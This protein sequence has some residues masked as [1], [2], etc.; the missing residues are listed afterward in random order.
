MPGTVDSRLSYFVNP[1]LLA[2]R[3]GV[4]VS[5]AR[6]PSVGLVAGFFVRVPL[7]GFLG[8]VWARGIKKPAGDAGD[9]AGSGG[10]GIDG[11]R[12]IFVTYLPHLEKTLT[13]SKYCL[14]GKLMITLLS[15]V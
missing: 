11:A 13:V 10:I 7:Q 9:P 4:G 3:Q 1:R 15:T 12:N 8:W 6:V 5:C 14:V 2:V